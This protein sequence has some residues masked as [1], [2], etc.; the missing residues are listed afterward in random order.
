MKYVVISTK[1]MGGSRVMCGATTKEDAEATMERLKVHDNTKDLG[2]FAVVSQD[3]A[4][5]KRMY[6]D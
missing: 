1:K 4:E 3:E 2:P 6:G 5:K